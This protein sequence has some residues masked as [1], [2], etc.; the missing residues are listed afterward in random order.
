MIFSF[1]R[2]KE[3][4]KCGEMHLFVMDGYCDMPSSMFLCVKKDETE[5]CNGYGAYGVCFLWTAGDRG[6]RI[7]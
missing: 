5:C 1:F 2:M 7:R 6:R 4:E 3:K